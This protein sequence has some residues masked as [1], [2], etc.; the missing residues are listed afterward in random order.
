MVLECPSSISQ[1]SVCLGS[2]LP[3]LLPENFRV[4]HERQL[5]SNEFMC[6]KGWKVFTCLE[7]VSYRDKRGA[8]L[9]IDAMVLRGFPNAKSNSER[10]RFHLSGSQG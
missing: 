4:G 8:V 10:M 2:F 7:M 3:F 6:R 5:N 9:Q 1:T